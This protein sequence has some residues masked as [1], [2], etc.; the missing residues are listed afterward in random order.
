VQDVYVHGGRTRIDLNTIVEE[1]VVTIPRN[2][3]LSSAFSF[4]SDFQDLDP[5]SI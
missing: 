3:V 1:G 5:V 2:S 4:L